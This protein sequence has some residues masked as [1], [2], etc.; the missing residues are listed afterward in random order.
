MSANPLGVC[1]LIDL[2]AAF[3]LPALSAKI[4]VRREGAHSGAG[5]SDGRE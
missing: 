3:L 2:L 4:P 5:H 1:Y